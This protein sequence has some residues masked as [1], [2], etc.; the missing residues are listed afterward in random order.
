MSLGVFC[1][2]VSERAVARLERSG[3]DLASMIPI[4][5][6]LILQTAGNAELLHRLSLLT[7]FFVD[8]G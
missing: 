7:T 5:Q 2:D 1:F 8:A 3:A 6:L 4:T